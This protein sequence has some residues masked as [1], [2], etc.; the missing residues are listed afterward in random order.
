M[1]CVRCDGKNMTDPFA[2]LAITAD[3]D[4][5]EAKTNMVA[6]CMDCGSLSPV[7]KDA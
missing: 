7:D 4:N 2:V 3:L 1:K 6:E 5:S